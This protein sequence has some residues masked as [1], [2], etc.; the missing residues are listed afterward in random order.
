MA[1]GVTLPVE[2]S[3]CPDC[4]VAVVGSPPSSPVEPPPGLRSG[5]LGGRRQGIYVDRFF[6]GR[7]R[8]LGELRD[9]C[10]AALSGRPGVV[11]LAGE[12]GIGKTRLAEETVIRAH[13]RGAQ[14]LW[15]R[16]RDL[17]EGAP[18]Y[19]PW[20][21]IIRDYART[22]DPRQLG[23]DLGAGATDIARVVSD[24][25]ERL[26]SLP[27]PPPVEGVAARFR[28]WDGI[29]TFLLRA[30][31]RQPLLLVLDDLHWADGDSL[32]LLVHVANGLAH[33]RLL[34][35]GTY[36]DAEV[37]R[38]HPLKEALQAL[39]RAGTQR[40]SLRGLTTPEIASFITRSTG[41]EP[42]WALVEEVQRETAGNPLF[43]GEV[44]RWLEVEGHLDGR[45]G[46]ASG[47]LGIPQSA[48]EAI[49]DWL[50]RLAARC[51]HCSEVL[52]LA[53]VVGYEFS[54]PILERVTDL[55]PE[56]MLDALEEAVKAR[57]IMEGGSVGRYRFRHALVQET[58]YA[59]LS[60]GRRL[61]LHAAVGRALEHIHAA[62]LAPY[63][64]EL[65]YHFTRAAPVGHAA[66]AIEYAVKAG[67]RAMIQL[68]WETAIQHYERALYVMDLQTEPDE[69]Q[70]CDVLLALGLARYRTVL[71]M[72]EAPEGQQAYLTAAVIAKAIGSP[73]RLARAA[74]E[75]AGVNVIRTP[76]ALV[77]VQLL[78][79]ALALAPD[80]DS[81]I[82]ALLLARLAVYSCTVPKMADRIG[83]I[84]EQALAMARRLND[85]AVLAHVL[86]ARY[87]A[88]WGPDTLEE[89]LRL[90]AEARR[91]AEAAGDMYYSI[92]S[93]MLELSSLY[94]ADDKPTLDR[95]IDHMTEAARQSRM[96]YF[97]W[98]ATLWQIGRALKEGRLA[99]AETGLESFGG[100]SRSLIVRYF[101]TLL[102][103]LVRREQAR[104]AE[105][106]EPLRAVIEMTRN[107][108]NP[109]DRHRGQIAR[110]ASVILL[111]ELGQLEEARARFEES[112]SADF[113]DLARDAYW[114]A[115]VVLLA[116][117]CV[118]LQ[119][120]KRATA[121]Y[122]LLLPYADRNAAPASSAVY[123]GAVSHYL[124][125]LATL[126][127]RWD[128]AERHFE[129]AL[130]RN[131]RMRAVPHGAWARA[132]YARMLLTRRS[133]GDLGRAMEL[134]DQAD[135]TADE[136]GLIRLAAE[137]AALRERMASERRSEAPDAAE[138]FGLSRRELEVLRLLAAGRSN[139]DI[140]EA[141]FISVR[142]VQTH[143]E[144]IYAKLGVHA[145][146]EAV[147]VAH[148]HGLLI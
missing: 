134:L 54:L 140:A 113:R 146:A 56:Q 76:D 125:L 72:S 132:S 94:E 13:L 36:R 104:L 112:A 40:I 42:E 117:V 45:P 115:T 57:L 90:I 9:A 73:E 63:Y 130:Q 75:Y 145:R 78:E 12:P 11:L 101:R 41:F 16:C 27:D 110:V 34:I 137:L 26:L 116:D 10:D 65:A 89:R 111:A 6:V 24:V 37:G 129:D 114:L 66:K 29:V 100:E 39:V 143:T 96:P 135:A 62:T 109:F 106:A 122:D 83:P 99:E 139:P 15:G 69:A 46:P 51:E 21:E 91:A 49:G 127:Q 50:D 97:I 19:W 136:I 60:A 142:T 119:D 44:V 67:D 7:A 79:D 55:E 20:V 48:V 28:L 3:H 43:V 102:L 98:S 147:D 85:P 92:F 103:F 118:L 64:G 38:G 124:G 80:Q 30:T 131:A 88:I 77:Q 53:S 120:V 32:K 52:Q 71:D 4:G 105:L 25:H 59:E 18:P 23:A 68:A 1:C 121:L 87:V 47:R 84:S 70:R 22:H 138:R 108:P 33:A 95:T 141:L 144:N 86:V 123:L 107:E 128:N 58:L 61:R 74:L 17:A 126:L 35:I 82:K 2:S 93:P 8:E 31:A 133:P 5:V 148:R 81:A 14:V